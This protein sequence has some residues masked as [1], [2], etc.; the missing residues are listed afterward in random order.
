MYTTE[1]ILE[2]AQLPE[3]CFRYRCHIE[4]LIDFYKWAKQQWT[5]SA[6]KEFTT[7]HNLN[8]RRQGDRARLGW[9][10]AIEYVKCLP[11]AQPEPSAPLSN[12]QQLQQSSSLVEH[13]LKETQ[14]VKVLAT[15]IAYLPPVPPTNGLEKT[16]PYSILGQPI[17][18]DELV[19]NYKILAQKWHPDLCNH[20]EAKDRFQLVT[21]IFQELKAN[22]FKKYSPLIAACAIGPENLKRAKSKKF[23]FT[24]ESFWA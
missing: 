7:E 4:N 18:F 13:S 21:A 17:Y 8:L 22:W 16:A 11:P 19:R 5:A 20:P 14:V 6:L 23:S 3:T 12:S 15:A 2:I 1:Q 9:L 24:P 10:M